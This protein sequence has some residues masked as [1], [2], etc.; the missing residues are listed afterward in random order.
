LGPLAQPGSYRGETTEYTSCT[1]PH[2]D[3]AEALLGSFLTL[4]VVLNFMLGFY[5]KVRALWLSRR[6]QVPPTGNRN[7]RSAPYRP[8]PPRSQN[9]GARPRTAN[10]GRGDPSIAAAVFSAAATVAAATAS[11]STNQDS[12]QDLE[13]GQ[14]SGPGGVWSDRLRSRSATPEP[15]KNSNP[16]R[17]GATAVQVDD[18]DDDGEVTFHP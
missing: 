6:R 7:P 8:G 17:G 1:C 10:P 16:F 18:S 14:A 2:D 15:R 5:G 13:T 3:L 4:S 12:L 9:S 11:R